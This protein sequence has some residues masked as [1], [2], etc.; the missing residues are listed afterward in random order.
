MSCKPLAD[1]GVELGKGRLICIQWTHLQKQLSFQICSS[2][3]NEF[4]EGK[5][6]S[7][8]YVYEKENSYL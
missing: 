2:N 4:L 1:I 3:P 6:V 8:L 7:R 5:F